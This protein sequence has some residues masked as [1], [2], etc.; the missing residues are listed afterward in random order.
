MAKKVKKSNDGPQGALLDSVAIGHRVRE[1]R[2][3]QGLTTVT[4]AKKLRMSQAQ[5]SR[6][7]N[8]LQGFRSITLNRIAKVLGVPPIYFLVEAENVSAQRIAEELEARGLTPSGTLRKALADPAFLRFI[9][10]CARAMDAH[11]KNLG[12]MDT[13]IR[14]LKL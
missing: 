1:L 8:G 10:Q 13:A 9:K 7:E 12:R 14:R 6:L 2:K 11:R 3:K 4:L 5:I